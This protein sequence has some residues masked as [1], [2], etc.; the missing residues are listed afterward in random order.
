MAFTV[1]CASAA[2]TGQSI[3]DVGVFLKCTGKT[4]PREALEAVRSLGLRMVQ[5]SKLPDR[6]YTPEGAREFAGLLKETGTRATAVVAVYDGESYKNIQAVRETVGF[7]PAAPYQERIAYTKKSVDFAAALGVK[8]VTFHVGFLPATAGDPVYQRMVQAV[9]EIAQ[10]AAKKGVTVSLETGQESAEELL[11]FIQRIPGGAV[12][13]N[14]DMANLVLYGKDESPSALRKLMSKVTSVHIKDGV[15]PDS[16][17]QLGAEA[18]LGEGKA[19]IKE[20]LQILKDAKFHGPLVLENYVFRGKKTTPMA[21]LGLAK[22]Y[23]Q[24]TLAELH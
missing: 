6:F 14:F 13:V 1:F 24:K 8:I 15:L 12:G 16:P 2:P 20:C 23:V 3:D 11:A 18:R 19:G 4:D 22:A 5:I 7:A 10:Y 17:S 21:E 9:T